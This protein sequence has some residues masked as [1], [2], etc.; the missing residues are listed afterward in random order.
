MEKKPFWKSKN[1]WSNVIALLS[2]IFVGL[3]TAEF[4]DATSAVLDAVFV[5]KIVWSQ[6][7]LAGLTLI[8]VLYHLI[9][10]TQLFGGVLNFL[11]RKEKPS[12]PQQ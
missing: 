7:F 9:F 10:K 3:Q 4:Q 11:N 2:T 8:N 12:T 1:F 5:E 6:V